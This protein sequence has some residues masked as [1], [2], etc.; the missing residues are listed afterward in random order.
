MPVGMSGEP[1]MTYHKIVE[2][3]VKYSDFRRML[4]IDDSFL[5]RMRYPNNC[6]HIKAWFANQT[7]AMDDD[8]LL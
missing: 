6:H 3:K 5:V 2:G 8:H 4:I 7:G 1:I